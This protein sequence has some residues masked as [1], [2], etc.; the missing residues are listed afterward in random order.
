MHKSF[1][2]LK[3]VRV[4]ETVQTHLDVSVSARPFSVVM[5][6]LAS[7]QWWKFKFFTL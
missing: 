6:L 5:L 4:M 2:Y 3:N 7:T 1:H